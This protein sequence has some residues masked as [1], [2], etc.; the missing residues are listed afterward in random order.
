MSAHFS[1]LVTFQKPNMSLWNCM[2]ISDSRSLHV[3]KSNL[4]QKKSLLGE[5]RNKANFLDPSHYTILSAA[6]RIT[7]ISPSQCLSP[8]YWQYLL[9]VSFMIHVLVKFVFSLK[10]YFTFVPSEN[11]TVYLPPLDPKRMPGCVNF[12]FYPQL[13]LFEQLNCI[14]WINFCYIIYTVTDWNIA[15]LVPLWSHVTRWTLGN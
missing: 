14:D 4:E 11:R 8:F 12:V 3:Q 9:F 10:H 6:I 13:V 1:G 5:A 2:Q 7:S 15:Y